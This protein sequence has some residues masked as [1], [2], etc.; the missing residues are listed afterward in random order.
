MPGERTR[1]GAVFRALAENTCAS[2][3]PKPSNRMARTQRL[4]VC[5]IAGIVFADEPN[6]FFDS[7]FGRH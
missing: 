7:H 6:I 4:L 5:G 2:G 3:A 1:P